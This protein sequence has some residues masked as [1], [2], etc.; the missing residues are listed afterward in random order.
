MEDLLHEFF[1]HVEN[2]GEDGDDE[3]GGDLVSGFEGGDSGRKTR[4][5]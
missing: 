3:E 5:I 2:D 4:K 1:S